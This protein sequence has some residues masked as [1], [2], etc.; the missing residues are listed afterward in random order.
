M[1]AAELQKFLRAVNCMSD[2]DF[3]DMYADLGFRGQYVMEKFETMRRNFI[4]WA[5]EMDETTM[6]K[7]IDW[8][9]SNR[10]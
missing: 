6:N 8:V 5:C 1:N 10:Y 9:K 3:M 2:L 4:L 7:I